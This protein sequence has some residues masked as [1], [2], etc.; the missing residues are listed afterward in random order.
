MKQFP[1]A[2][3]LAFLAAACAS[4]LPYSADY[5]LTDATL[6]SR[7]GV[8]TGRIP[9]GWFS[10]TE[11]SL[12][13]AL[14][15][16]LIKEDYSAI[17]IVKEIRLD[18]LASRRVRKEGLRLLAQLSAHMDGRNQPGDGLR[19]F[20]MSGRDY[21]SYEFTS[22]ENISRAVVFS[23]RGRYYTCTAQTTKG[24]RSSVDITG[25]F[26]AQQTFLASLIY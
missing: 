2:L 16:W 10:S 3:I 25:M 1:Y 19:E 12:A 24:S 9:L 21:C 18:D 14:T 26:R 22:A 11:D 8:L 13:E 20:R 5:P 4:S 7:D 15:A 17:L 6:T 23:A